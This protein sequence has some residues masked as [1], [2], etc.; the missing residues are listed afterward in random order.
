MTGTSG[1]HNILAREAPSTGAITGRYSDGRPI[2]TFTANAVDTIPA[3]SVYNVMDYGAVGDGSTDDTT[4]IQ[5]AISAAQSAGGGWVELDALTYATSATL[6]FSANNVGLRGKGFASVIRPISGATFDV[7]SNNIPSGQNQNGNAVDYLQFRD[8]MIDGSQMAGTVNHTGNGLHFYGLRWSY[9][10][11]LYLYHI[12][13]WAIQLDGDTTGVNNTSYNNH[14]VGVLT[15]Q[16]GGNVYLQ[17]EASDV[18]MCVF[19]GWN[20]TLASQQPTFGTQT[21]AYCLQLNSG[22]HEVSDNVFGG[23]GTQTLAAILCQNNARSRIISNTFDTN[24]NA[25][26][27][28]SGAD[29]SLIAYNTFIDPAHG[30]NNPAL[31]IGSN[32]TLVIGNNIVCYQTIAYTYA[33]RENGSYTNNLYRDNLF[34]A[35]TQGIF[36]LNATSTTKTVDNAGYNPLGATMTQ[37]AIPASGTALTNTYGVDAT[38]TVSGGTVTAIAI[39]GT[40]TGLIAGTFRVPV[41]Q[42]ITLTYSA[43][44]VWQ[45]YGD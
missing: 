38:V 44:P 24:I 33:L 17:S 21:S 11:N 7:I 42:T 30:G 31:S 27:A 19:K 26:I 29:T 20:A 41:G 10:T 1:N 40:A 15:D 36:S 14:I 8:F 39:G 37:P 6:I 2:V 35:G 22:R 43:A 32:K 18:K 5:A 28:T 12:P 13:N 34:G 3:G 9:I 16:C 45:W 25:C 23:G 4:A